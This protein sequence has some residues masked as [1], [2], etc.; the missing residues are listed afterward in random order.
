MKISISGI[1][2]IY[3]DDLNLHDGLKFSRLFGSYISKFGISTCLLARDTRPSSD[4]LLKVVSAGLMEQGI[5]VFNLNVAPTPIAF[6]ESRKYK[7]AIIV[8]ASHNPLEWNGLKFVIEGRGIFE[9]ELDA[10]LNGSESPPAITYGKMHPTFSSYIQDIVDLIEVDAYAN[11]IEGEKTIG[12][13][14]GG[15]AVC[16]FV[17][18]LFKRLGQKT[19][20]INDI[21]G[22]SSRTPDPTTDELLE[23][24]QLVT[25]NKLD[26][27]FAFD[28]DGDRLVVIDKNGKKLAPDLTLLLCLAGTIRHGMKKYVT[29]IDTSNAISDIVKLYGGSISYSKV[30]EANVV[31]AM[32]KIDAEAGGEGSSAGFIMPKFNM[33]RDG[34]LSASIIASLNDKSVKE[35]E[36]LTSKYGIIRT[37]IPVDPSKVS[38]LIQKLKER[39]KEE[40]TDV[41]ELD[42]I[43]AL[44]DEN[45]WILIRPSNT[46]NALR[47][48]VESLHGKV[49][50]L[51]KK[52]EQMVL[53]IHDQIK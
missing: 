16:R 41:L 7:S 4:I 1:R 46:E 14:P 12:F 35:C 30:G 24:R 3:D 27:G 20:S 37:K 28:M 47:I 25:N 10:M 22:I 23:L 5:N 43:K 39:L 29:S 9:D 52:T 34:M 32:M 15:G 6:R 13:D 42:G 45:S 51:Y 11:N 33:C 31:Q 53:S 40:S 19:H 48:S 2:G 50:A 49:S 8:T 36:S 17:P 38:N 44:V 21:E 26:F 18:E